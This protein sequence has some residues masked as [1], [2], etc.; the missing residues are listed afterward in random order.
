MKVVIL[1]GGFGSR[2]SEFTNVIPKPMVPIGD[3]PILWHIMKRYA[4]FGYKDFGVALGYKAEV[5]KSYF[6]NYANINSDISVD[7]ET[8]KI[9]SVKASDVDWKVTLIDTGLNTKTGGR[10]K[11]MKQFVGDQTFMVTYGD[12]L[13]DIDINKLVDFHRS[14]G[15][16][17]TMTA[18][19]PS[20]RF[21][22]LQLNGD[23]VMKF[24]EKPQLD[25][26]WINGGFFVIEPEFIQFIGGD[27][28]ML[29][30]EPLERAAEIGELMAYR[31]DGFWQCMDT[32]RDNDLL[33]ELWANGAPWIK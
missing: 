31:H 18:V 8:G 3:K 23:V 12:G 32:K 33:E 20:A 26:G 29:E 15:K 11:Q 28:V 14:H 7:L 9:V 24:E 1:A 27:D 6:S 4:K 2:L 19:R 16:L 22:E 13:A 17:I 21:G 30:R 5:V 10:V 25:E